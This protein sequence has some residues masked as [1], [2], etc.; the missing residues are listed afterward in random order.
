MTVK[1]VLQPFVENVLEHAWYDDEIEIVLKAGRIGDRVRLEVRDNG[2]GMKRETIE[3]I[4]SPGPNRI[5]F[6]IRNVD[7]RLKL[8]FGK[9]YGVTL[10]RE[11]G[12]GTSA[13][14][15]FPV[16]VDAGSESGEE[17]GKAGA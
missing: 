14:L 16:E 13:V 12:V 3:A 11:V 6:G 10:Y 17:A 2:I 15:E 5:G 4:F 7:Q 1:F 8:H 9:E